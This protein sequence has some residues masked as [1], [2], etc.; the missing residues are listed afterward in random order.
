MLLNQYII[1]NFGTHIHKTVLHKVKI[2]IP[3]NI[4]SFCKENNPTSF[5]S[6][7]LDTRIK[8]LFVEAIDY[9]TVQFEDL[10]SHYYHRQAKISVFS[11]R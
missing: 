3:F 11:Q 7:L 4:F 10:F 5:C 1:I 9:N 8:N 2:S 6:T